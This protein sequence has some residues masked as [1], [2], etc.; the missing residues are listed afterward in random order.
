V[1]RTSDCPWALGSAERNL[2]LGWGLGRKRALLITSSF[3]DTYTHHRPCPTSP[4]GRRT[5][6]SGD[7]R[8]PKWQALGP[9]VPN[10]GSRHACR[11]GNRA[12]C[13]Q[14]DRVTGRTADETGKRRGAVN[15]KQSTC[16]LKRHSRILSANSFLLAAAD[17]SEQ[18][19]KRPA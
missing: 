4:A 15:G 16:I 3:L 6:G 11:H 14:G 17:S 5:V 19:N 8:L 9:Q 13:R 18:V 7:G 1:G 12:T 10:Q 2:K